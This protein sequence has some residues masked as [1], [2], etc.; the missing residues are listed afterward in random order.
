MI[1][2]VTICLCARTHTCATANLGYFLRIKI[3]L[4]HTQSNSRYPGLALEVFDYIMRLTD[5]PYSTVPTNTSAYGT[6]TNSSEQPW[7]GYLGDIYASRYD[8]VAAD[9]CRTHAKFAIISKRV[10]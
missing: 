4:L 2:T 8:T 9:L 1:T 7:T 3:V 6:R 5:L 10:F